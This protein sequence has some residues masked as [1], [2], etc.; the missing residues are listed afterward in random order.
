ME[1]NI[2]ALSRPE[3][4]SKALEAGRVKAS[5]GA[6]EVLALVSTIAISALASNHK[7]L[8]ER[9][10]ADSLDKTYAYMFGD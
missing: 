7:R 4:V 10:K 6:V 9:G 8:S 3:S 1:R 5:E 2:S